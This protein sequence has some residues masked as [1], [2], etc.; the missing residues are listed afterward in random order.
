MTRFNRGRPTTVVVYAAMLR[1]QDMP[2]I[3]DVQLRAVY[4]SR[5]YCYEMHSNHSE[6][7]SYSLQIYVFI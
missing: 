6:C 5:I 7:L 3:R 2:Y 4:K 1:T